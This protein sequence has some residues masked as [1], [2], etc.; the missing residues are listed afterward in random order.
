ME[1]FIGLGWMEG[2]KAE[3]KLESGSF[4]DARRR[5]GAVVSSR[6]LRR[7]RRDDSS[8]SIPITGNNKV[9]IDRG[10]T[11]D[12]IPSNSLSSGLQ[13]FDALVRS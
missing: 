12:L 1:Y 7:L 13:G 9:A 11:R 10:K 3:A 2:R 6:T 5:S 4:L 8:R